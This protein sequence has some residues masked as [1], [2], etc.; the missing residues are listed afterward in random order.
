M[1]NHKSAKIRIKR[2][3]KAAEFNASYIS[4]VRTFV[5]KVEKA[6]LGGNKEEAKA[7][8]IAAES[9]LSKAA[10]KGVI[11]PLAASRKTS[12]LSARVKNM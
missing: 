6:I 7:N 10:Q 12:R 8:F 11:K 1:A 9:A 4:R 5:K 2:N 3:Q